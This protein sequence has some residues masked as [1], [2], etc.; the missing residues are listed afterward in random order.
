[1]AEPL[2][3]VETID[4]V[5][6]E[7]QVCNAQLNC[8]HHLLNH[9]PDREDEESPRNMEANTAMSFRDMVSYLYS[10]LDH[11][12][13]FLYCHFQNNGRASFTNA[14][15]N[16]KQPIAHN[17]KFSFEPTR[18]NASE[19]KKRRN[20]WVEDRCKEIF[21]AQCYENIELAYHLRGFQQN[22]LSIQAITEVDSAGNVVHKENNDGVSLVRA[23]F[24]YT[25]HQINPLEDL[26]F[27]ELP[28]VQN[29]DAWNDAMV[30][31]L[32]HFFRNFTTHRTLIECKTMYGLLNLKTM[33]FRSTE[34]ASSNGRREFLDPKVWID[35]KEGSWIKVPELSHL[36]HSRRE[37]PITFYKL[38]MVCVSSKFL[39]F[40][41]AQRDNLRTI[42][43]ESRGRKVK[44]DKIS[45]GWD[46][47]KPRVK[48]NGLFKEWY[49]ARSSIAWYLV[50]K[51]SC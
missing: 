17:L 13:Y 23:C 48:I 14:A 6:R 26:S 30:F 22:L 19:C 9:D 2:V 39:S 36:K 47:D 46:D 5:L 33:E 50:C 12:F 7:A 16:I 4:L 49:N 24:D 38:P 18:D 40:V 1:M 34:Q 25:H 41:E 51:F 11:I 8:I 10:V 32:L 15:F 21:G 28:S 43:D 27:E 29:L 31:N 44:R 3:T 45:F 35:I 42:I 37:D 20:D